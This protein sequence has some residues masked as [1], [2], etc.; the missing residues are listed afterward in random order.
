MATDDKIDKLFDELDA[1]DTTPERR[2]AIQAELGA[3]GY[4]AVQTPPAG[5]TANV[6]NVNVGFQ[7]AQGEETPNPLA[8]VGLGSPQN[9]PQNPVDGVPEIDPY[10]DVPSIMRQP[11]FYRGI[12]GTTSAGPEEMIQ[13]VQAQDPKIKAKRVGNGAVLFERDD[14]SKFLFQPGMSVENALRLAMNVGGTGLAVAGATA[15]APSLVPAAVAARAAPIALKVA[16]WTPAALK[17]I[18]NFAARGALDAGANQLGQRAAGAQTDAG[19]MLKNT[20][21]G[22]GWGA[23]FGAGVVGARG[24]R[25]LG[26][27]LSEVNVGDP[28]SPAGIAQNATLAAQEDPA[29]LQALVGQTKAAPNVEQAATN[30]GMR[31]QMPVGALADNP[32]VAQV[33]NLWNTAGAGEGLDLAAKT[34]REGLAA[35]AR[36]AIGGSSRTLG[37]VSD[38]LLAQGQAR[39]NTIATDITTMYG[40]LGKVMKER[41]AVPVRNV[42]KTIKDLRKKTVIE[43]SE[44]TGAETFNSPLVRRIEKV[45]L[46]KK[47]PKR[48]PQTGKQLI[49]KKTGKPLWKHEP[50]TLFRVEQLRR[51]VSR[52][53]NKKGR[54]NED[55]NQWIAATVGKQLDDVVTR[56]AKKL[57]MFEALKAARAKVTEQFAQRRDLR[58][59]YGKNLEGALIPPTLNAFKEIGTN[60]NA[61]PLVELLKR[62]PK[63]KQSEV[64]QAGMRSALFDDPIRGFEKFWDRVRNEPTAAAA[65]TKHLPPGAGGALD[66]LYTVTR[67]I[68]KAEDAGKLVSSAGSPDK[69]MG[70]QLLDTVLG[71]AKVGTLFLQWRL[72]GA[73][74]MA[75]AMM[76]NPKNPDIEVVR[77]WLK[78][79]TTRGVLTGALPPRAMANSGTFK[80]MM[81]VV[82]LTPEKLN[83]INRTLQ[84]AT[85]NEAPPKETK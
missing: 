56:A 29:A 44:Q 34:A 20:V 5:G 10:A 33:E 47:V 67:A 28:V 74:R 31:N 21:T 8:G 1:K 19:T 60:G 15:L 50:P 72:A 77:L 22:A 11:E 2:A 61:A 75:L 49:S 35:K 80:R 64:V 78:D 17:T 52:A 7:G 66:D 59:I 81:N 16:Q 79:P 38:D 23:G 37:E 18:M 41:M 57:K 69:S 63:A 12:L 13:I 58:Y 27:R 26:N 83:W 30:L 25:Q 71:A 48:D 82:N 4:Y 53:A 39:L 51:E 9:V 40:D 3:G 36:D 46:G 65:I 73:S 70:R 45:L 24:L 55:P 42:L 43:G 76:R 62:V 54:F 14:K 68:G 32:A 6:T 84:S 85:V